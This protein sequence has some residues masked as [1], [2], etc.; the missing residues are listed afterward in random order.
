MALGRP[1]SNDE[2]LRDEA[3]DRLAAHIEEYESY[4]AAGLADRAKAVAE[5]LKAMGYDVKPEKAPAG[6]KERAVDPVE[7]EKAVEDD[8]APKRR[9][10]PRKETADSA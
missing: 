1:A 7:T 3:A 8:E 2:D 6:L 10:R 5:A 4:A 9:G